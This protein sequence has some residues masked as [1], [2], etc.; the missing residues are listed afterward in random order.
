MCRAPGDLPRGVSRF[1]VPGP[2][3]LA[4]EL[5]VLGL[6]AYG[7]WAAGSRAAGETLLT[8]GL[9]HYG[10]SWERVRWLLRGSRG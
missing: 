1:P 4:I 10:L 3:R 6:A 7:I 9:I 2:A 5:A 8:F